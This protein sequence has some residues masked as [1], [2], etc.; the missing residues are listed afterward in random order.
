[1]QILP[2]AHKYLNN[3]QGAKGN[4]ERVEKIENKLKNVIK[5]L[6]SIFKK[7]SKWKFQN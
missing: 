7:I 2:L 1:M 6:E 4:T 3:D 5:K